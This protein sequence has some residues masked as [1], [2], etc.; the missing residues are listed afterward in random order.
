MRWIVGGGGIARDGGDIAAIRERK[1][2]TEIARIFRIPD[3]PVGNGISFRRQ[4]REARLRCR[5]FAVRQTRSADVTEEAVIVINGGG[6]RQLTAV[7]IGR[8]AS[9]RRKHRCVARKRKHAPLHVVARRARQI[10]CAFSDQIVVAAPQREMTGIGFGMLRPR[11][12]IK[13]SVDIVSIGAAD[14]PGGTH[15]H[16]ALLW[17]IAHERHAGARRW[18][19]REAIVVKN[20]VQPARIVPAQAESLFFQEELSRATGRNRP[21]SNRRSS[22]RPSADGFC[23]RMIMPRA[24]DA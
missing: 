23:R 14:I 16:H 5:A 11:T 18:N 24:S 1:N 21:A 9:D 22:S 4:H 3:D 20:Q 8:A 7:E 6:D 19:R 13:P 17:H 15:V 2:M 12:K 10:I